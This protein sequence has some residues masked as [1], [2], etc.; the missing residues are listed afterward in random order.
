V[1]LSSF[2]SMEPRRRV[3]VIQRVDS[4]EFINVSAY[5]RDG[6]LASDMVSELDEWVKAEGIDELVSYRFRGA[7]EETDE[8]AK[9]LLSAFGLALFLMLIILVAQFNSFYQAILIISAVVMSTA[10]VL[11]GLMI[12]RDPF[13]TLLT[14]IG[15][16]ALAG[17]VVNNN[18][19]LIDTYNRLR[20]NHAD[21]SNLELAAE[22]AKRRFRPVL[23]TTL[24]TVIGL[25][26][27]ANGTSIDFI[28]RNI[29]FGGPVASFWSSLASTIVNGLVFST[30]LTLLLTP[31]MLLVPSALWNFIEP[32]LPPE[33]VKW[34]EKRKKAAALKKAEIE[35]GQGS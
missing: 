17:I 1:P 23:L 25:L 19:V 32:A 28:N 11:L 26:P 22:S 20:E 21:W 24:T 29:V 6:V 27:L 14:G 31:T 16:V 8:S 7:S 35:A 12:F 2:V 4:T 34:V 18:I 33:V 13:S 10:G 3:D 5:T 30:V 15:V 9:F